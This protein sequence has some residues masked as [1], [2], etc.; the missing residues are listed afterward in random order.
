MYC[1]VRKWFRGEQGAVAVEFG[2]V[3]ILF[4]L[5]TA[6]VLDFGHAWY[7][8]QV[9]TNASRE[10]ARY[11]ITYRT[12]TNGTRVAPSTLTPNLSDYITNRY[13][14]NSTLP[15]DAHPIITV[16]GTGYTSG[17]K[18][19]PLE[20]TISTTKTWFLVSKLVPGLPDGTTLTARTV[21]LCE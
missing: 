2:V 15:S 6:A 10:G 18:G 4:M 20:V 1:E 8:R 12:D 21:M 9:I 3:F 16:G 11:G 14:S 19:A 7:M 13:L 17:A 5:V